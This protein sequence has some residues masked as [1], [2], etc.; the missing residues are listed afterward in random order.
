MGDLFQSPKINND[1][2]KLIP[3]ADFKEIFYFI[4]NIRGFLKDRKYRRNVNSEARLQLRNVLNGIKISLSKR[5][6]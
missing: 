1:R 5:K 6:G 3:E 2:N 4:M